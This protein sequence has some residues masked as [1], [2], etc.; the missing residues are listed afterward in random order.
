[1]LWPVLRESRNQVRDRGLRPEH[2]TYTDK[3]GPTGQVRT[4]H[5]QSAVAARLHVPVRKLRKKVPSWRSAI[6]EDVKTRDSA[7]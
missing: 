7:A 2:T 5:V 4:G 1:M 6:Q 3:H